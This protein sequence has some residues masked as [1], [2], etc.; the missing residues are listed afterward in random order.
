MLIDFGAV[1]KDYEEKEMTQPEK[2]GDKVE[3]VPIRMGDIAIVAL[4]GQYE[5]ERNLDAN[6][7]L[8]RGVLSYDIAK[9]LKK[10]DSKLDIPVEDVAE[11]KD[12]IAKAYNPLTIMRCYEVLDPK[13]SGKDKAAAGD[14]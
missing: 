6:K 2:K 4:N 7:K 12:L 5:T 3:Q 14:E 13:P 9:A 11:I 10:K 1:L 8:H